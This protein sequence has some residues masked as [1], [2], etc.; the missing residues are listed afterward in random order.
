MKPDPLFLD[1]TGMRIVIVRFHSDD[2]A[3]VDT[4][5]RDAGYDLFGERLSGS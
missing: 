2:P 1:D 3:A 5:L 4:H